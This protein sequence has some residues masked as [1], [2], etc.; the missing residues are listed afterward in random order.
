MRELLQGNLAT[1]ARIAQLVRGNALPLYLTRDLD[2][3]KRY[4]AVGTR[5][6]KRPD[7]A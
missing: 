6:T 5:E 4:I 7:M 2:E 3:A 1:A